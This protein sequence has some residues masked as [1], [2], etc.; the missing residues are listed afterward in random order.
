MPQAPLPVQKAAGVNVLPLQ[1]ALPHWTDAA[2]C[3]QAPPTQR[4]VLPQ[5]VL[6]PQPPCGSAERLGTAEQVPAPL[7]LQAWQVPHAAE[8][9]QTPS[10]QW[11]V[12]HSWSDPQ[13]VPAALR[14][15][16]LPFE[17]V[18]KFPAVQ[19][20]SEAQVSLHALVLQT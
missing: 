16:Q 8:V 17:P 2:A 5:V 20:L 15:M 9:Q 4:P 6:T 10:V 7:T 18:Q 11:P 14:V 1:E 19:S 12:P 3:W 13:L